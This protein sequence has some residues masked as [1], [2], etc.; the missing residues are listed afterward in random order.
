MS[1]SKR[2]LTGTLFLAVLLPLVI[3]W[4]PNGDPPDEVVISSGQGYVC[5]ICALIHKGLDVPAPPIPE[6]PSEPQSRP[7]LQP[8]SIRL[9]FT[10]AETSRIRG[11]PPLLHP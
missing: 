1:A 4:H 9:P 2:V 6:P 7:E 10:P 8:E 5:P 11:P 3:H